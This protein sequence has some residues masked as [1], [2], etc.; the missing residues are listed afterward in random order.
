MLVGYGPRYLHSI[1]QLYKGAAERPLHRANCRSRRGRPDPRRPGHLRP[2]ET[3]QALGDVERS[4]NTSGRSCRVHLKGDV[5]AAIEALERVAD[6]AL[7][8]ARD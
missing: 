6:A 5:V 7:A 4:G 2:I 8:S 3:A 1:G